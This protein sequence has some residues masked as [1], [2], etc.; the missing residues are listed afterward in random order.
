M[1]RPEGREERKKGEGE[2]GK[3]SLIKTGNLF[4]LPSLF[5]IWMFVFSACI[6][7]KAF[8]STRRVFLEISI[9]S[10]WRNPL[11]N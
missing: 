7:M 11:E 6:W 2:M 5:H 1:A 9:F 10:K 3:N 8:F 4:S